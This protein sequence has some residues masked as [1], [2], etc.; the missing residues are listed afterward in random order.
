MDLR[1]APESHVGVISIQETLDAQLDSKQLRQALQE[2]CDKINVA[3]EL[4]GTMTDYICSQYNMGLTD[5]QHH[6]N[7]NISI[8]NG[9]IRI[10]RKFQTSLFWFV[11]CCP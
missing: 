8:H 2:R 5:K 3:W 1:Q 6:Y 9:I 11:I 10:I 4:L 7:P